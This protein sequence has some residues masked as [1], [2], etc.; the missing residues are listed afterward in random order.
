M[1]DRRDRR[2]CR[3]RVR[4]PRRERRA[5]GRRL[6]QPH[7]R[8]V[9]VGAAAQQVGAAVELHELRGRR[10]V[11]RRRV[12]E[13]ERVDRA[14]DGRGIDAVI[15]GQQ[16][17]RLRLH[18]V[19]DER[20]RA[21]VAAPV[22]AHERQLRDRLRE[23]EHRRARRRQAR[24]VD[25]AAAGR[26]DPRLRE[27]I[28]EAPAGHHL[29]RHARQRQHAVRNRRTGGEPQF[30]DGGG[31]GEHGGPEPAD[32]HRGLGDRRA[33]LVAER[34]RVSGGRCE[35]HRQ[36][37]DRARQGER[38]AQRGSARRHDVDP[39]DTCAIGCRG[40]RQARQRDVAHRNVAAEAHGERH[41]LRGTACVER[42]QR[43]QFRLA[44]HRQFHPQRRSLRA[45]DQRGLRARNGGGRFDLGRRPRAGRDGRR[46]RDAGEGGQRR[47]RW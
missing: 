20:S 22:V 29:M 2:A 23:R 46:P 15:R 47:R 19:G 4:A 38:H 35:T 12:E 43:R 5:A 13:P 28:E 41:R 42:G 36:S 10:A 45:D 3:E 18:G 40:P 17:R 25:V 16:I 30:D 7:Q 44:R 1:V 9:A 37:R 33:R 34:G 21:Q 6:A 26:A 39:R 11:A 32:A 14:R 27:R 31:T 8:P 24:D